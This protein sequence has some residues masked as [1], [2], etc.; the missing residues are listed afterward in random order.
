VELALEGPEVPSPFPPPPANR[1]S[2]QWRRGAA[3]YLGFAMK[4]R[5]LNARDRTSSRKGGRCFFPFNS[6]LLAITHTLASSGEA[7]LLPCPLK[8]P[9]SARSALPPV[10]VKQG[11][12]GNTLLRTRI[13]QKL[14][15]RLLSHLSSSKC[16][17]P[18]APAS[19]FDS[20]FFF[21]FPP[22]TVG[23]PFPLRP[24][25]FGIRYRY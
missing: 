16:P 20:G 11:L 19:A 9:L 4:S 8:V 1:F 3:R 23:L 18:P 14:S 2:F 5:L 17:P 13:Q 10:F 24:E 21:F 6:I 22:S 12:L 15:S 7:H 25:S